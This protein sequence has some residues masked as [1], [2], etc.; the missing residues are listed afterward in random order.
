MELKHVQPGEVIIEEGTIDQ[1]LFLLNRGCLEVVKG[2][3]VVAVLSEKNTVF[4]ELSSLLGSPRSCTVRAKSES[5]IM[6]IGNHIDDLIEKSPILTRSILITLATRLEETTRR[7]K[8]TS[9]GIIAFK[10][11]D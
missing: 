2:N 1:R 9:G 7:L 8:E 4:G 6:V 3:A 5:E 10:H 11:T